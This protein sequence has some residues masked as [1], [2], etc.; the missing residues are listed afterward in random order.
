M[1][2]MNDYPP[3]IV[4][5]LISQTKNELTKT[6]PDKQTNTKLTYL[7]LPYINEQTCRKVYYT[8]R[9]YKRLETTR[10]TFKSGPR[11]G[12][13]LTKSSLRHTVCNKQN[14]NKCY[15]CDKVCMAKNV[16]Y[17]LTCAVCDKKYI[18]ETGRF[19]RN[20]NWEHFKSVRD[21]NRDTAM[22][23]HYLT[24]HPNIPIP[25][26]PHTFTIRQK[27]KDFVDRQLWQSTLIKRE[28]PE[29]N[30]QLS[31]Y[32]NEGEWVKNTWQLM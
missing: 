1:L 19:K 29:L 30:T 5:Q 8:L 22:G 31:Q 15:Q 7:S 27:C 26:E 3:K 14:D 13:T 12:D 28:N 4:D 2:H 18:G 25:T 17:Q 23:K 20:R 10:V 32:Q 24:D 16:C 21:Q 9:K 6:K 11:L